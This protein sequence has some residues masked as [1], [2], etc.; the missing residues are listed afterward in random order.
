MKDKTKI[1]SVRPSPFAS[2]AGIIGLIAMLIFGISTMPDTGGGFMIIW[3]I[4]AIGGIIYF[5][6]N[7]ST[8]SKSS[9]GKSH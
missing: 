7:L 4:F 2:I 3:V 5:L 6:V 8:Y 9:K 1:A